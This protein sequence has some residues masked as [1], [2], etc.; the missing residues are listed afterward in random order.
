MKRVDG[1]IKGLAVA[2]LFFSALFLAPY[3]SVWEVSAMVSVVSWL[4]VL[5]G[6]AAFWYGA[7]TFCVDYFGVETTVFLVF[8]V[9]GLVVFG[10]IIWADQVQREKERQMAREA[11]EAGWEES[12]LGQS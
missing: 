11:M 5:I 10:S 12:G 4:A 8:V 6:C 3:W 2:A 7:L 9:L 1:A